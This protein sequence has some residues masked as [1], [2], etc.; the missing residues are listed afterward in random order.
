MP[1]RNFT[2]T[3][4]PAERPHVEYTDDHEPLDADDETA[5]STMDGTP[6]DTLVD[7]EDSTLVTANGDEKVHELIVA[8][9]AV[10]PEPADEQVHSLAAS[11]G[12]DAD[13]FEAILYSFLQTLVG[14]DD[15]DDEDDDDEESTTGDYEDDTEVEAALAADE[16]EDGLL[17]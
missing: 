5:D 16:S 12:M 11:V 10:N 14:N 4:A 2:A 3:A 7:D 9:L 15:E 17:L 6:T 1:I 8:F 13:A